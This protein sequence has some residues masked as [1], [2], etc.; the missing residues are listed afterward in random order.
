MF[1]ASFENEMASRCRSTPFIARNTTSQILMTLY[2]VFR[3]AW[4]PLILT[5]PWCVVKRASDGLSI[6]VLRF[7]IA[8][9]TMKA[10]LDRTLCRTSHI[11]YDAAF[12]FASSNNFPRCAP[13]GPSCP[14][15]SIAL[16]NHFTA[17]SNRLISSKHL[18]PSMKA[19]GFPG[20][21]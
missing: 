7:E 16:S 2:D 1:R 17:S 10:K 9:Q 3:E 14:S 15:I 5:L 21:R 13:S 18:P 19:L 20:M 11:S 8:P 12:R 6:L 4:F